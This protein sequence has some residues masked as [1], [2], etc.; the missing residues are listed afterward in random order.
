MRKPGS[1]ILDTVADF[2][3]KRRFRQWHDRKTHPAARQART[4]TKPGKELGLV[5]I[6]IS[7]RSPLI[8]TLPLVAAQF[9][10]ARYLGR[11]PSSSRGLAFIRRT[12]H[13]TTSSSIP[14]DKSKLGGLVSIGARPKKHSARILRHG[15]KFGRELWTRTTSQGVESLINWTDTQLETMLCLREKAN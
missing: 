15:H 14:H 12:K 8:P 13:R 5:Y 4:P 6:L 10:L 3:G 9:L 1:R 7:R 2:P 11:A